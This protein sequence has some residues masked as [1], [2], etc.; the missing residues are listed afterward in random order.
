MSGSRRAAA[1]A[2]PFTLTA[3]FYGAI[4]YAVLSLVGALLLIVQA[5]DVVKAAVT[6]AAGSSAAD[7][8]DGALGQSLLDEASGKLV[9]RGALA[10]I[11]AVAVAGIALLARNGGLGARISLAVLLL[12]GAGVVFIAV[13]DEVPAISKPLDFAA[14]VVAVVTIVFLFAPANGRYAKERKVATA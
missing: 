10:A 9:T 2:R 4:A 3:G 8:L 5:K 7:L 6:E 11:V 14:M 1:P 13:R 12:V